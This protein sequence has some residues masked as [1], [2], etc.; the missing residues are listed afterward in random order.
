MGEETEVCEE[1]LS[2]I[3]LSAA[4][5]LNGINEWN[6]KV[7]TVGVCHGEDGEHGEHGERG[8]HGESKKVKPTQR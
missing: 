2:S 3:S 6:T 7:V 5:R 4:T 8:E 1:I